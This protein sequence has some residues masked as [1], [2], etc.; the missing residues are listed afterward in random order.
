MEQVNRP[1]DRRCPIALVSL[2][3]TRILSEQFDLSGSLASTSFQ[4]RSLRSNVQ[5]LT[6]CPTHAAFL[7][8]SLPCAFGC[9]GV[10]HPHI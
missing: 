10:F 3:V 1:D 4:V 2:Q 5:D 9:Y 7:V 8:G 6:E